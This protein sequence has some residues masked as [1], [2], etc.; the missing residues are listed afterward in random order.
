MDAATLRR[1][2]IRLLDWL[3]QRG[4]DHEIHEHVET[5]TAA[6]TARAE[7]VDARTFAKVV[8]VQTHDGRRALCVLDAP[9]RLDLHKAAEAL[10]THEVRLLSEPE[11]AEL[12]PGCDA[13]AIPAIGS[14]FGVP[15]I[16]DHAIAS[17]AEISFNA[18]THRHAIRVDR[19][20]W[21]RATGVHYADL[22]LDA[23]D[24]PAWADA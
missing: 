1:P 4:V 20:D 13:G 5:F 18:G 6:G 21:E 10:G 9:D 19:G 3:K 22:A 12:A 16:A 17:D 7:G 23:G 2:P 8:G 24:R 11:L 15:M 14:L